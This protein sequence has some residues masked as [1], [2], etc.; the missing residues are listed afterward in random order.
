MTKLIAVAPALA[1]FAVLT[2][3]LSTGAA[4]A[5]AFEAQTGQLHIVKDCGIKRNPANTCQIVYS[6]LAQLPSG[7]L[8]FY[9][10]P[11][12]LLAEVRHD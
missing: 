7:S 8:I 11:G 1:G 9:A 2:F 12:P 6:N 4:P 3:S 10:E 5:R